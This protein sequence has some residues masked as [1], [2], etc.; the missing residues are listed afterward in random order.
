[1]IATIVHFYILLGN[2]ASVGK[3]KRL[4]FGESSETSSTSK[5]GRFTHLRIGKSFLEE[6]R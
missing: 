6:T 4:F 2:F 5:S 3:M 1:M